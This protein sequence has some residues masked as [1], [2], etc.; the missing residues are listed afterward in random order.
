M[1]TA[2][3][4]RQAIWK[5]EDPSWQICGLPKILYTDGGSDF[6]STRI[7]QVCIRLK[8]RMLNSAVGRPQGR[9]KIERFFQTLNECVLIDLPG[10]SVKGKPASKPTLTLE[11]LEAAV[12]DFILSKY[13]VSNH[14]ATGLPP[15]KMWA[16]G[17]LPQLPESSEALTSP[18]T[19]L[20]DRP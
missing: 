19:S 18:K 7:E 2:L 10:Y 6:M 17:F 16:D 9:G 1:N 13:H 4:L 8:I 12:I 11:Q 20:N 3:A 15:I 5:K 14:S